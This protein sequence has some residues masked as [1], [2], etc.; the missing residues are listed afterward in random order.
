VVAGGVVTH[1][2]PQRAGLVRHVGKV[3]LDVVVQS[4]AATV[5]IQQIQPQVVA[6]EGIGRIDLRIQPA[7]ST[8][9]AEVM[10]QRL[11]QPRMALRRDD[12]AEEGIV[13]AGFGALTREH[14]L[15]VLPQG[16]VT[17]EA[18]FGHGHIQDCGTQL[19]CFAGQVAVTVQLPAGVQQSGIQHIGSKG[20]ILNQFV[21]F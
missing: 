5:T 13:L 6:D 12:I 20:H 8:V 10:Q 17:E 2:L 3:A 15:A 9:V 14:Q 18:G 1:V 16:V 4:L 7:R 21:G 19:C 11:P